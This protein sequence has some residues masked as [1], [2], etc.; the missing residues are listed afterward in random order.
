MYVHHMHAWCPRKSDEGM[1]SLGTE[2][3]AAVWVLGTEPTLA[4]SENNRHF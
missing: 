3:R 1:G 2:V 4:L